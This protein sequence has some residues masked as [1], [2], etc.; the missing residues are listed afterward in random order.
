MNDA[1]RDPLPV[2]A[3]QLLEE[4]LILEQHG[5][6]GPGGLGVLVVGDRCAG[7]GRERAGHGGTLRV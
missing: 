3:G 5:P 2:E 7:F 1:L 4:V 6:A